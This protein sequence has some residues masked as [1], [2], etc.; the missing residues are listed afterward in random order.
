MTELFHHL[1]S[2]DFPWLFKEYGTAIYIVLFLVIFIETG[3][4]VMPFLPGDSLLF[5]SGMFAAQGYLSLSLILFMLLAAAI[6][7]DN[8]N[9]WIGRK[10]GLNVL[11]WKIRGRQLVKE[12]YLDQTHAFFEKNGAKAIIMARFVPIVRTFTPFAAGVGKMSYAKKFLPY[13]V[14]GGFLWIFGLTFAG[15]FLGRIAWIRENIDLVCLGIILISV[16]PMI[17]AFV[18]SKLAARRA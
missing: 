5:A 10:I 2:L 8:V 12:K 13:D 1:F 18:K 16:L 7:G 17:F 3:L 15:Y 4:V 11:Q 14:L 6:L 9:Y